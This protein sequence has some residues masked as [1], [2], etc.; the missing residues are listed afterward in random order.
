M[1]YAGEVAEEG[2]GRKGVERRVKKQGNDDF[3][4]TLP[5]NKMCQTITLVR[6]KYESQHQTPRDTNA[7][8]VDLT[9]STQVTEISAAAVIGGGYKFIL[10]TWGANFYADHSPRHG[11]WKNL[12]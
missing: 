12:Q 1:R 6:V 8:N 9:S 5:H 7:S 2:H 11:R 3:P 4:N 10:T